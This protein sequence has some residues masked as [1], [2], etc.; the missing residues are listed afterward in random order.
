VGL[1]PVGDPPGR[2]Y[3]TDSLSIAGGLEGGR[4]GWYDPAEH[5]T[6][7]RDRAFLTVSTAAVVHAPVVSLTPSQARSP[8]VRFGLH[9]STSPNIA[10]AYATARDCGCD[11][12]QIFSGNPTAWRDAALTE[13]TITETHAALARTGID[14]LVFHTPYL[15]NLA[16]PNEDFRAKSMA[17]LLAALRKAGQ[18]GVAIVNTHVGNHMGEGAAAGIERIVSA[19]AAVAPAIPDGCTLVLENGPGKGTE[20]GARIE[21]LIEVVRLADLGDRLGLCLDTA[22]L[23]GAG[24]DLRQPAVIDDLLAAIDGGPGLAAL[25]LLHGNDT[26]RKLGSRTDLHRHPGEGEIGLDAFADLFSRPRLAH[27]PVIL[28]MPG[29]TIEEQARSL[30]AVKVLRAEG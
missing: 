18:L 4:T 24:Y 28:E 23:W 21:E 22:H 17:L 19:L 6:A 8:R 2:P 11:C 26:A 20:I 3:N 5:G 7:I 30:P 13:K 14:P 15:I 25:R 1:N 10:R 12:V 29:D 9:I 16:T 27:L